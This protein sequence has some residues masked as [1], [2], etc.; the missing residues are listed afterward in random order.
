ML[1]EN[2][3]GVI[4]ELGSEGEAPH[5]VVLVEFMGEGAESVVYAFAELDDPA[6]STRVLKF[7]KRNPML[8]MET[9]HH[10]LRIHAEAYPDHPLLMSARA[11]LDMLTAEMLVRV[12]NAHLLFSV[13]LYLR[14]LN[15][16]VEVLVRACTEPYARSEP[17]APV[18]D[19]HPVREWFDD[20]L[21][22]HIG[23]LLD[24][25]SIVEE[26]RPL[27]ERV[28]DEIESGIPRWRAAG[29]YF[30]LSRNPLV[31]LIG[32]YA[33]DF[34]S[35]DEMH[36]ISGTND[37]AARLAPEHVNG[38][39]DLIA[40]L[41]F[42]FKGRLTGGTARAAATARRDLHVGPAAC[43][44]LAALGSRYLTGL[45]RLWKA[46]HLLL[47]DDPDRAEI[48]R[49][50]RSALELFDTAEAG[51]DRQAT[52]LFLA[53]LTWDTDREAAQSYLL[54]ADRINRAYGPS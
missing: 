41:Y 37:F 11:R 2:L 8:E 47:A 16:T 31:N 6:T 21:V 54:E 36:H 38:L 52:F 35:N 10:R 48:Q 51:R 12:D 49:I 32:L 40:S 15:A 46:R 39:F 27:L 4:V 24:E 34:I 45:S 53:E 17:L 13:G 30:P 42:H 1:R 19:G 3:V 7:P 28:R 25:D 20:N 9:L 44:L 29:T 33:E 26:H 22:H 23:E 5:P 14:L 18:L 43:D 50:A